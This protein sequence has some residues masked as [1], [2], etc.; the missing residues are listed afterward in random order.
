FLIS[1]RPTL[2]LRE[3]ETALFDALENGVPLAELDEARMRAWQEAGVVEL[4]PRHATSG[5]P[6][7]AIEPHM[8]DIALSIGGRLLQRRGQQSIVLLACTRESNVSC[9]WSLGRDFFDVAQVTALRQAESELAAEFAGGTL[10][11]LDRPDAPLRFQP[12]DKWTPDSFLRMHDALAPFLGFAPQTEDV[13][14]LAEQ[15][16]AE[17]LPLEPGELWIPLGLG[18]HVDH[19][20]TRDACLTMIAEHWERFASTPIL[21]YEDHPYSVYFPHQLE[22]VIRAFA[23]RGVTLTP[24]VVD[25]GATFDEK[26][27]FVSIYASQF[28]GRAMEP[29][30]RKRALTAGGGAMLAE[31]AHRL[32]AKP[33]LPPESELAPDSAYLRTIAAQLEQLKRENLQSLTII[34]GAALGP[35]PVLGR[36]LTEAFPHATITLHVRHAQR[37]ETE[38]WTHPRVRVRGM[39]ALRPFAGPAILVRFAPWKIEDRW[40]EQILKTPLPWWS[41][42]FHA[43]LRALFGVKV[44]CRHLGD[45]C[46]LIAEGAGRQASGGL[47]TGEN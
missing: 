13:R 12:A 11:V 39:R 9:Y 20:L 43:V 28:K 18:G 35:W 6:L 15:I 42:V 23:K 44:E 47:R 17:V 29:N 22:D 25:I 4:I 31:R 45:V 46:A 26:I 32:E 24:D 1:R 37:W 27:R 8:D 10:R 30:L 33:V 41:R 36:I 7:V 21:L 5:R 19:R 2:T 34:C 3:D 40:R 14:S 16:A 38:S